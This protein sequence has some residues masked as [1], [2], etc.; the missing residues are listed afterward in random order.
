MASPKPSSIWKKVLIVAVALVVL[1]VAGLAM[2]IAFTDWNARKDQ[3]TA[4]LSKK[5]K[6]E[7]KIDSVEASIFTG[8]ALNKV[9]IA[10]AAGFSKEPLFYSERAVF[11]PSLLSLLAGKVVVSQLEFKSPQVLIQKNAKGVY[12]FSDMSSPEE[13]PSKAG[14]GEAKSSYMPDIIVASFKLS[15]GEFTYDAAGKKTPIKGLNVTLSGF[16]LRAAGNSRLEVAMTPE[17]EGK[18]IPISLTAD[19]KLNLPKDE[20]ELISAKLSLPGLEQ[21]TSGMVSGL[22]GKLKLD[23]KQRASLDM[24]K[25]LGLLP[26]SLA[27]GLPE[28][29]SASGS[30][31]AE[32]QAKGSPQALESLDFKGLLR[33]NKIGVKMADSP[34]IED[35]SGELSLSPTQAKLPALTAK[36]GGSPLT[37]K[38]DLWNYSPKD[39]AAGAAKLQAKVKLKLE[40]KAEALKYKTFATGELKHQSALSGGKVITASNLK[41]YDGEFWERS[42]IDLNQKVPA[43]AFS[44]GLSKMQLEKFVNAYVASA[45]KSRR[46]KML[47]DKVF[48]VLSFKTEGRGRGF[49]QPAMAANLD[50]KGQFQLNNGVLK[51]LD[52]QE[53]LASAIPHPP[54]AEALRQDIDFDQ[55]FGD[56]SLKNSTLNLGQFTL[57]SGKD[58]REGNLLI[59]AKGTQVIGGATDFKITPH[60]NPR[61][62]KLDGTLGDAFND[63]AGWATYDYLGYSGPDSD[64]AKAD[65]KAGAKGAMNRLL[66]KQLDQQKKQLQDKAQ[67][68]GKKLLED[69]GKDILKLFGK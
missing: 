35:I 8:V 26:P 15:D 32:S 61:V 37:L 58:H 6:H 51:K 38:L 41:L 67:E 34:P 14:A 30:L 60:F 45:P 22:R 23:L 7:V 65:Y 44:A 53:R 2:V 29:F 55:A 18:K 10:N 27:A 59:Q 64:S 3:A 12:N 1:A 69:K 62:V 11:R 4:F 68:E 50:L 9:S 31:E 20:L 36:V 21:E 57:S 46:I 66:Q 19:F 24:A 39:L 5:L 48:G 33:F 40:L 54:T 42:T 43:Y 16:S 49:K 63:D 28:G 25:V 47:K 13:K 52:A 56:F 17:V